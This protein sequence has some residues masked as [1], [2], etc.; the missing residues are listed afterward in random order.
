ML[1]FYHYLKKCQV[2][3]EELKTLRF[4]PTTDSKTHL[5][6][7]NLR[8]WHSN[9]PAGQSDRYPLDGA[10]HLRAVLNS[11]DDY[12]HKKSI[13]RREVLIILLIASCF[14]QK[15]YHF[16]PGIWKKPFI[17]KTQH[18]LRIEKFF[19]CLFSLQGWCFFPLTIS[20]VFNLQNTSDI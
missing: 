10:E 17:F 9:G 15:S 8:R 14:P 19:S 7:G 2:L 13:E 3:K 6:P 16:V 20:T 5:G 12:Q 4:L 1:I 11:G 18:H